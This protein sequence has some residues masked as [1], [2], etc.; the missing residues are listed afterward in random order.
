M[1]SD[2][3]FHTFCVFIRHIDNDSDGH[4][5]LLRHQNLLLMEIRSRSGQKSQILKSIFLHKKHMMLT[6][7]FLKIPNMSFVF[8]Y[9]VQNSQ[10]LPVKILTSYFLRYIL[11]LKSHIY[12][13][14]YIYIYNFACAYST[15]S[16]LTCYIFPGI[17]QN[18]GFGPFFKKSFFTFLMS[19]PLILK[20]ENRS[21]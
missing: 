20:T 8:I 12:I 2:I 18:F 21:S 14:I 6:K 5:N 7:N 10:T 15:C 1:Q 17:S 3:R 19:N 13:Y 16:P 11:L 9:D 4:L